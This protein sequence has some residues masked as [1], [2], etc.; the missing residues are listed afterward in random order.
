MLGVGMAL[1]GA[2]PGTLLPQLAIGIPSGKYVLTG[3]LLGGILYAGLVDH[4]HGP[5]N[6]IKKEKSR[7]SI[8]ITQPTLYQRVGESEGAGVAAYV[9]MCSTVIASAIYLFPE[10]G[11]VFL[12]A[13]I[14]GLFIGLSQATS[15]AL[16]GNTLGVSSAYEQFGHLFWWAFSEKKK[17]VPNYKGIAFPIGSI[18]GAFV[19]SKLVSLPA[20]VAVDV[21]PI[22]ALI[23]GVLLV[24]G[25]RV[26][27]GCTSGHGISGMSMLS[28]S[29]V[30]S[31][32]SM[33]GT[34]ILVGKL[35]G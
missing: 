31:V 9:A 18:I 20:P 1:T 30:V 14:G 11:R 35:L 3:G 7:E 29:S 22:K 32:A 5:W 34:G 17:P 10:Q 25:G 33:F 27:G 4:F 21:G 28:I 24:L 23:G 2:C 8:A 16:T 15:L 19:L 12:P 13:A 26:G 6:G